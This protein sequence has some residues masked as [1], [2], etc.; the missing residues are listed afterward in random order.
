MPGSHAGQNPP[1]SA[2]ARRVLALVMALALLACG[3][4]APVPPRAARVRVRT[5]S[6][7]GALPPGLLARLLGA[8]PPGSLRGALGNY[9]RQRTIFYQHSA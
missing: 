3:S 2:C 8:K 7:D 5:M 1:M 4:D 6:V 9:N